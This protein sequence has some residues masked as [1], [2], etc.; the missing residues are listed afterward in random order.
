MKTNAEQE[1]TRPP[2]ID[3]VAAGDLVLALVQ[4]D[5]VNNLTGV[6]CAGTAMARLVQT[7]FFEVWGVIAP[8]AQSSAS[9]VASFS[10]S[11]GWGSMVSARWSNVNS[12]T[13][14]QSN[15]TGGL[16]GSTTDRYG[17]SI[18]TSQRALIV[19][20]GTDWNNYNTH[21]AGNGYTLHFANNTGCSGCSNSVQWLY[22][23][24]ADAGTYG[25]SGSTTRFGT[26][27]SDS[28]IGA[29]LAFEPTAGGGGSSLPAIAFHRSQH[30]LQ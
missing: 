10:D 6:T 14:L 21:T 26:A 7:F 11:S 18:T 27:A 15:T 22:S 16:V 1:V 17:G 9:I 20:A 30:G 28:I 12:A 13:P 4:R 3:D 19:G 2:Q 24:V 5:Y 23:K 29:T 25:A 8:S